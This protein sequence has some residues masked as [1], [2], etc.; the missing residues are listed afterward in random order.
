[1]TSWFLVGDDIATNSFHGRLD[2]GSLLSR[3]EPEI[4]SD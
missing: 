2:E 4:R 1:M 3:V